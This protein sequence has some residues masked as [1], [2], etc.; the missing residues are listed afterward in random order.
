MSHQTLYCL[1]FAVAPQIRTVLEVVLMILLRFTST[2]NTE[3]QRMSV[4][5]SRALYHT[6][7]RS[8]ERKKNASLSF[9]FY[10]LNAAMK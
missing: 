1:A 5:F 9:A 7:R 8:G 6:I 4:S 3:P 2:H 10:Q